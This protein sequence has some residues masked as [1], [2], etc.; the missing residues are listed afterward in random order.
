[1]GMFDFKN[2]YAQYGAYGLD[3]KALQRQ[4]IAQGLLGLSA[5]LLGSKTP[6]EG[7]SRGLMGF[8][9][10][11]SHGLDDAMRQA[12]FGFNLEQMKSE[13]D[14]EAAKKKAIDD[15][16]VSQ[17]VEQ[18]AKLRA[19]AEA[20]ALDNIIA[21]QFKPPEA[22]K[23]REIRRG[24]E[25]VTQEWTPDKG[26]ADVASGPAWAPPNQTTIQMPKSIEER[27]QL[28]LT[29]GDPSSPDY[30]MA[31][32]RTFGTP[33]M[34]P[35]LDAKGNTI[36][37]PI[38]MQPPPN[39]RKPTYLDT[40]QTAGQN[41]ATQ[42]QPQMQQTAPMQAAPDGGMV[43]GQPIK[44]GEASKKEQILTEDQRKNAQLYQRTS[45]QL[46]ILMQNFDE[47]SKLANQAGNLLPDAISS[48]ATSPGFQRANNA[49]TDIASSYLYSVSGATA[50]PGEVKNLATTLTP[51]PGESQAS[52]DDKKARVQ[53]MV[54]SIKMRSQGNT[55]GAAAIDK[56]LGIVGA[57]ATAPA[58]T[59]LKFD[60]QGNLIP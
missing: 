32:M 39:L 48:F 15:Y 21:D 6:G 28:T 4:A 55:D 9:E 54:E 19:A 41:G 3:P 50:N 53:Q 40:G 46:P 29:T 37:T 20:G 13:K 11:Q 35:G 1:M 57:S 36:I 34:V 33:K 56:Q 10:A 17:P 5:G 23:T 38:Y 24:T 31:W 8:Q 51:R 7:L 30:A 27:D 22:P 59:V 12:T 58:G 42:A 43:P 16:I 52:L 18:Q 26:W 49:L 14:K 45:Q 47:L 60:A 25:Q 44:T 2:P